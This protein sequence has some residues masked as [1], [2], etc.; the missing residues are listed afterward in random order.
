MASAQ[1]GRHGGPAHEVRNLQFPQRRH[2]WEA[3]RSKGWKKAADQSHDQ[4]VAERDQQRR[5]VTANEKAIW[6]NDWK[7]IVA[8]S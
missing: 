2:D 7:F 6:L 4:R 8:V 1:A 5:G 3:G